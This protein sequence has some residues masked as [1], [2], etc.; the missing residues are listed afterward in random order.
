MKSSKGKRKRSQGPD[1]QR[2]DEEEVN[3]QEIV[4]NLRKQS[5][6][7]GRVSDM[8]IINLPKMDSLHDMV[9]I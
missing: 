4:E 6:L 3:K 2:Q 1:T 5:V 9:E 7:D 8:G